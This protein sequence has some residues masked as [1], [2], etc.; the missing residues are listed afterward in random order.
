M[1][2]RRKA[3]GRDRESVSRKLQNTREN[4]SH[5]GSKKHANICCICCTPITGYLDAMH[6]LHRHCVFRPSDPWTHEHREIDVCVSA[7]V[8][9]AFVCSALIFI[10]NCF[11]LLF[12]T[13]QANNG[14]SDEKKAARRRLRCA[15]S[16]RMQQLA[17]NNTVLQVSQCP[18][19]SDLFSNILCLFFLFP[20]F[21]IHC[22]FLFNEKKA[23]E[24]KGT[25]FALNIFM[26]SSFP[27]FLVFWMRTNC[28]FFL[29]PF[30]RFHQ[31]FFCVCIVSLHQ[32][33]VEF[34]FESSQ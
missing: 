27:F 26:C 18:F 20:H 6:I 2:W 31:H 1:R 7:V 5:F 11:A 21:R 15:S 4:E 22:L 29:V 34:H 25:K 32:F 13:A 16:L 23:S 33:C 3:R 9:C 10:I 8:Q 30:F 12:F 19:V 24:R 28:F 17:T 14:E